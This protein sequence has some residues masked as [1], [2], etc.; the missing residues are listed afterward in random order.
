MKVILLIVITIGVGILNFPTFPYPV[1]FPDIPPLNML[2]TIALLCLMLGTLQATGGR[3]D[4]RSVY[5]GK[6]NKD[7][8]G[9]SF[10]QILEFIS[11]KT[12]SEIS[13]MSQFL[14]RATI[15]D[16]ASQN[17][18]HSNSNLQT[19]QLEGDD[20]SVA[21]LAAISYFLTSRG[22]KTVNQVKQMT[23]S[24]QYDVLVLQVASKYDMKE[25]V[26]RNMTV[27]EMVKRLDI[28]FLL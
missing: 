1:Q 18:V 26:L 11:P 10:D 12:M 25:E 27:V 24:H 14:K 7:L 3:R 9:G 2:L 13:S 5:Q 17:S 16:F 20:Q 19:W 22:L 6:S 21:S 8:S 4:E 28:I 15:I 23:F